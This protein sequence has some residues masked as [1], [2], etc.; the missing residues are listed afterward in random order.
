MQNNNIFVLNYEIAI[1]DVG[2]CGIKADKLIHV[3]RGVWA[4]PV[5]FE[6]EAKF[7]AVKNALDKSKKKEDRD[8]RCLKEGKKGKLVVCHG[9]CKTCTEEDKKDV[10]QKPF[11]MS[12]IVE[13]LIS[14]DEGYENF[15][16][17]VTVKELL[18]RMD[19]LNGKYAK[20]LRYR[21]KGK[22]MQDIADIEGKAKSTVKETLDRA[23]DLAR[24]IYDGEI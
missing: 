7:R 21:L 23:Y 10:I 20:Y 1:E 4:I 18:T 16:D 19:S 9:C 2:C 24:K 15:V 22:S 12:D 8:K 17:K 14:N 13:R 5:T 3:R 6:D 11:L